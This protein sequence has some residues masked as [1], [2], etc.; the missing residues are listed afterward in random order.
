MLWPQPPLSMVV[1]KVGG[2]DPELLSD[3]SSKGQELLHP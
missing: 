1:G 2:D 3:D